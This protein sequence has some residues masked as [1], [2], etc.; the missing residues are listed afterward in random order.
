MIVAIVVGSSVVLSGRA[1]ISLVKVS[2]TLL[3]PTVEE[4]DEIVVVSTA[5]ALE[6]GFAATGIVRVSICAG[7]CACGVLPL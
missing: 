2:K 1:S 7:L 6:E 4:I 3:D 5:G